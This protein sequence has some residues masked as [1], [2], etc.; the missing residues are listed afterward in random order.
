MV[1]P[2]NVPENPRN[3]FQNPFTDAAEE[4]TKVE[5][6]SDLIDWFLWL[7]G[8]MEAL[9]VFGVIG[10]LAVIYIFIVAIFVDKHY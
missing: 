2:L 5:S 3:K 9:V 8:Y 7:P 6:F 10:L 4:L 1:Q